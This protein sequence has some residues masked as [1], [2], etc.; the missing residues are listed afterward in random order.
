M[1][2]GLSEVEELLERSDSRMPEVFALKTQVI[3]L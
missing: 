3:F 2:G 1:I